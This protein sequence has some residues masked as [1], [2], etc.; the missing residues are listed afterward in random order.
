MEIAACNIITR[1]SYSYFI[2]SSTVLTGTI[3]RDDRRTVR[4][5]VCTIYY[6]LSAAV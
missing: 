5:C 6:D 4:T 3:V 2:Y 1:V